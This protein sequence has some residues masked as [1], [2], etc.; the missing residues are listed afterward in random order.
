MTIATLNRFDT[1]AVSALNIARAEAAYRL[2]AHINTEHLLL[3]LVQADGV[4]AR[5]LE[6][7]GLTLDTLRQK[8]KVYDHYPDLPEVPAGDLEFNPR[9]RFISLTLARREADRIGHHH[10]GDGHLLLAILRES[11]STAA[12]ILHE[13]G[14]SY[15]DLVLSIA[16]FMARGTPIIKVEQPAISPEHRET[17]RVGSR[18]ALLHAT[19][20]QLLRVADILGI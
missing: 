12:V 1:C 7:Y 14:M 18:F 5:A 20:E 19:D 2:S 9:A 13:A 16:R 15:T 11:E 8:A 17:L 3:G 10:V 4:A 6:A